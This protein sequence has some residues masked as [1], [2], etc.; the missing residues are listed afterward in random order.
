MSN[1]QKKNNCNELTNSTSPFEVEAIM[2]NILEMNDERAKEV[3]QGLKNAFCQVE[4]P[5]S[6]QDIM[7]LSDQAI[8]ELKQFISKP[9]YAIKKKYFNLA[10]SSQSKKSEDE[11]QLN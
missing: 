3:V 10:A 9:F 8:S 11:M 2:H 1:F 5:P 4:Q 6:R 7:P